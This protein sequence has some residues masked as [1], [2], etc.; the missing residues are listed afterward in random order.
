[1]FVQHALRGRRRGNVRDRAEALPCR[2]RGYRPPS[3][4]ASR[5]NSSPTEAVVAFG[6][7]V[8]LI[9]G[10]RSRVAS[11]RCAGWAARERA[12]AAALVAAPHRVHRSMPSWIYKLGLPSG[13]RRRRWSSLGVLARRGSPLV[14][15]AAIRLLG[16][17]RPCWRAVV[18][19]VV[20][21]FPRLAD[22]PG[23]APP[24]LLVAGDLDKGYSTRA[25]WGLT[26]NPVVCRSALRA[27][28]VAERQRLPLRAERAY[29]RAGRWLQPDNPLTWYTLGIF[30][31]DVRQ[32]PLR[33]R[34]A[35]LNNSYTLDPAETQWQGRA[36]RSTRPATP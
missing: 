18:S 20:S 35:S 21:P 16:V 4:T 11:A 26:F 6:L 17:G 7:F 10:R 8:V 27:A 32:K 13:L 22:R 25:R 14:A 31:F 28:R 36:A 3:R 19:R 23:A 30:E 1:M 2:T 15:A 5:F 12:A 29:I 9:L 24:V 34:T 33:R